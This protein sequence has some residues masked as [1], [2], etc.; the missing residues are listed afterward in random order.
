MKTYRTL[1]LISGLFI[2][3][4][5]IFSCKKSE[6]LNVEAGTE[7]SKAFYQSV[8]GEVNGSVIAG[9]VTLTAPATVNVNESFDISADISCGKVAIERGYILVGTTKVYKNLTCATTGLLWEELITFQC[10]TNDAD[11]T[12]SLSEAGTYVYRTKHNG[13][14]GNCDGLGGG[15]NTSECSFNGNQFYCFV[16]EA[17]EGCE[18]SFTGQAVSCGTS[19]EANYTFISE[20]ALSYIKIQG[21][22]TN[23]TGADA[24]VTVTGGNL[25]VTQVTPGGSSNRRITIEGSVDACETITIN[26]K[27]NSSNTGGTITGDW[28][29]K[30]INGNALAPGIAGLT[31]S[32]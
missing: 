27:W 12:G 26:I 7:Q 6:V 14:G 11:W 4:I 24:V 30:D 23:F 8:L 10:Y 15:D 13:S 2:S 28:S 25:T 32:N 18:T 19:R 20:D 17:V 29:V 9:S 21:G 5:L 31:C 3:A 16:I 22:L 1:T